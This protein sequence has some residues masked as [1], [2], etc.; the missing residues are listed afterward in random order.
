MLK[1]HEICHK[2]VFFFL[3]WLKICNFVAKLFVVS[4]YMETLVLYYS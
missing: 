1:W 4:F 3:I 2:T